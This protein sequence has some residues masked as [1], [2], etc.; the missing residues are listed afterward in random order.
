MLNSFGLIVL[1]TSFRRYD[2]FL[3]IRNIIK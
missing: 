3:A 1:D 2:F